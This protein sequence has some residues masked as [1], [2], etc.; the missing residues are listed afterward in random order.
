MSNPDILKMLGDTRDLVEILVLRDVSSA[1][2]LPELPPS[3]PRA[4]Q[5]WSARGHRAAKT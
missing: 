1:L 3:S 2:P 4:S 5:A